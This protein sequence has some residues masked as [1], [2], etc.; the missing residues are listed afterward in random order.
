MLLAYLPTFFHEHVHVFTSCVAVTSLFSGESR[1][2]GN[3]SIAEG[4]GVA[5]RAGGEWQFR[6]RRHSVPIVHQ[7]DILTFVILERYPFIGASSAARHGSLCVAIVTYARHLPLSLREWTWCQELHLAP[8]TQ[9]LE[10]VT[11][12]SRLGRWDCTLIKITLHRPR[13][14]GAWRIQGSSRLCAASVWSGPIRIHH[15]A[16]SAWYAPGH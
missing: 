3:I 8:F 1:T 5:I 16:W 11:R 9:H 14:A 10:R 7:H 4:S 13:H 15:I 12:S 2:A 6:A